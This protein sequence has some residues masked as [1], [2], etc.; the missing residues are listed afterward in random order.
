LLENRE[1]RDN[2]YNFLGKKG[3]NIVIYYSKP[4]HLQNCFKNLGYKKGDLQVTEEV[5]DTI[6]TV[7]CYAELKDEEVIYVCEAIKEFFN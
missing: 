3:V 5:C 2:L 4:L 7:P 1:K 6:L